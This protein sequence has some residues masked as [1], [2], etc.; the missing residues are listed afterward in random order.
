MHRRA[1]GD[2]C[3]LVTR[4]YEARD[5]LVQGR[6]L[7]QGSTSN[8]ESMFH[9]CSDVFRVHF[10]DSFGG[11]IGI[12]AV[13]EGKIGPDLFEELGFDVRLDFLFVFSVAS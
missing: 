1:C 7:I 12:T 11:R 10:E 6:A 8:H 4:F 13:E 2:L 5:G 3:M 9:V